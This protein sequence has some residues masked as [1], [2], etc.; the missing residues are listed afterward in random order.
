M[1]SGEDVFPGKIHWIHKNY[2]EKYWLVSPSKSRG[3]MHWMPRWMRPCGFWSRQSRLGSQFLWPGCGY[4]PRKKGICIY[5][6]IHII[7]W[8]YIYTIHIILYVV[9]YIYIYIIMY[10]YIYLINIVVIYVYIYIHIIF[11]LH[12]I[13]LRTAIS[14]ERSTSRWELMPQRLG[15]FFEGSPSGAGFG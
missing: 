7:W 11:T 9:I 8:L 10:I 13:K 2:S 4:S 12:G 15:D 5:I 14:S 6:Y 3:Y 1:L